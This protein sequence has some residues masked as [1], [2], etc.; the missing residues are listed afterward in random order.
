[1]LFSDFS[2]NGPMWAGSGPREVRK[3]VAFPQPFTSEPHVQVAISLWDMDSKTNVR[4]DLSA[5][6]ITETHFT[7]VFRTW[8]DTRLARIRVEWTAIGEVSD[9][10]AWDVG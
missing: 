6:S 7:I 4:M 2:D 10:D 9:D 8:G 1:M 5:E 3:Q